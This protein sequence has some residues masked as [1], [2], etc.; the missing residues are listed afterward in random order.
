MRTLITAA[1]SNL[2]TS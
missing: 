1:D 2:K